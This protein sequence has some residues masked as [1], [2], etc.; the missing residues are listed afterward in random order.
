LFTRRL[1]P[2]RLFE[3]EKDFFR[4]LEKIQATTDFIADDADLGELFGI[5]RSSRTGITTHTRNMGV[6]EQLLHI[7]NRWRKE[8]HAVGGVANLDMADTYSKLDTLAP[9]LLN[10]SRPL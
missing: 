6:T 7:F 3:F 5:L 10:F 1:N 9:M 2:P 8:M 4:V